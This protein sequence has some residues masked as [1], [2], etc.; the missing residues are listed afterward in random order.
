MRRPSTSSWAWRTNDRRK[1]RR[2][3]EAFLDPP[4]AA[5]SLSVSQTNLRAILGRKFRRP[6]STWSTHEH[7]CEASLL[8]KPLGKQSRKL[9]WLQEI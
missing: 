4:Y 8:Q 9:T 3:G 1:A 2:R 5:K 6:A 7:E